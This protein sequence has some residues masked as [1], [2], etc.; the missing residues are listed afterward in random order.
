MMRTN[1]ADAVPDVGDD[2][3]VIVDVTPGI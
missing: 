3:D 2:S 1:A